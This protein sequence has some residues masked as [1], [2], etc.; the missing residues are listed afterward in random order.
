MFNLVEAMNEKEYR[1][2]CITRV[3]PSW[4]PGNV[5]THTYTQTEDHEAVDGMRYVEFGTLATWATGGAR[6]FRRTGR[7]VLRWG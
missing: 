1:E 3:D 2:S 7:K 5:A 4:L 6:V